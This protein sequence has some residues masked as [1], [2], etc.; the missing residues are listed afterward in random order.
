MLG[1]GARVLL[2]AQSD[3]NDRCVP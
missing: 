1:G 2:L 3:R